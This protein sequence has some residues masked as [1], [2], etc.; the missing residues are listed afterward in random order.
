MSIRK[1]PTTSAVRE[2]LDPVVEQALR[3]HFDAENAR[4]AR[5]GGRRSKGVV[6]DFVDAYVGDSAPTRLVA[7]RYLD[8][9][10]NP[11]R[12][13]PGL[14]L[15]DDRDAK[16][17]TEW[18]GLVRLHE[19][20][21][22]ASV[23]PVLNLPDQQLLVMERFGGSGVRAAMLGDSVT[24]TKQIQTSAHLLA[25][26][27]QLDGGTPLRPTIDDVDSVGTALI[28]F[29][30]SQLR[31]LGVDRI[32]GWWRDQPDSDP[33][34]GL[35]HN[36][37]APRNF[38]TEVDGR[39]AIIDCLARHRLPVFE[40]VATFTTSVRILMRAQLVRRPQAARHGS[41]FASAF[42]DAY[43]QSTNLSSADLPRFEALVL[44][45]RL[46]SLALRT[47]TPG[48]IAQTAL[49]LDELRRVTKENRT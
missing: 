34:L 47:R 27:H 16:P 2:S 43:L 15:V 3:A 31:P 8:G 1:Q 28:D 40:D 29:T 36:D 39:V 19:Q 18:A 41:Q 17:A 14:G 13:R 20:L 32:R 21:P 26:L 33:A 30:A 25:T 9:A 24:A 10:P 45:D 44:L 38:V 7:K 35:G 42:A 49:V 48:T 37:C 4:L 11:R 6:I 46:A 5:V 23:E 22:D 12:Q